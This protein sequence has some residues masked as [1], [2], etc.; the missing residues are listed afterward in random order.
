MKTLMVSSLG[1]V[2]ARMW[3]FLPGWMFDQSPP[4]WCCLIECTSV[5]HVEFGYHLAVTPDV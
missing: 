3:P 4:L 1:Y 2:D 5:Y